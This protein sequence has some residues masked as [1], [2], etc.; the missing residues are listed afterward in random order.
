MEGLLNV[1][2]HQFLLFLTSLIVDRVLFLPPRP[3]N[4]GHS[5]YSAEDRYSAPDRDAEEGEKLQ[6]NGEAGSLAQG[7]VDEVGE[8][9]LMLSPGQAPQVGDWT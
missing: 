5:H 6:Q 2:V 3:Q 4:H 7:K 1:V 9:E 8:G